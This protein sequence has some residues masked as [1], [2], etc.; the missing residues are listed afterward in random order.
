MLSVQNILSI[1]GFVIIVASLG[2]SWVTISYIS[3]PKASESLLQFYI[4]SLNG[5]GSPAAQF[6]SQKILDGLELSAV[7]LFLYPGVLGSSLL[8][9]RWKRISAITTSSALI[10]SGLWIYSMELLKLEVISGTPGILRS[11]IGSFVEKNV[12]VG[13][14]PYVLIAGGLTF[15]PVLFMSKWK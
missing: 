7:S 10:T 13:G 2:L 11:I 14:G 5:T 6:L 4:D 8:V 9:L 15:L 1:I 3:I 12:T